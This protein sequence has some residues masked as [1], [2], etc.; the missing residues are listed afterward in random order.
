MRLQPP[1]QS[2]GKGLC[3]ED[4][5]SRSSLGCLPC[6]QTLPDHPSLS[7]IY[8]LTRSLNK[9]QI[10]RILDAV[11]HI[12]GRL[13]VWRYLVF[14]SSH[15]GHKQRPPTPIPLP[16]EFINK[17]SLEHGHVAASGPPQESYEAVTNVTAHKVQSIY[18]HSVCP[19]PP[20]SPWG[21][22]EAGTAA[23]ETGGTRLRPLHP[24]DQLHALWQAPRE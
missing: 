20:W 14:N 18:C 11:S 8:S 1:C 16:L 15:R 13:A 12:S 23:S 10:S 7:F 21:E 3:P 22:L 2:Y 5:S 9:Y 19:L 6:P 4:P 24:A 17:G